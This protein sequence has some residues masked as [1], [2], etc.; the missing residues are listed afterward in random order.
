MPDVAQRP[1]QLDLDPFA[2]AFLADPFTGHKLLRD[3]GPVVRLERYGIWGMA[4]HA[5]VSAALQDWESFCSGRGA[6]LTDFAKEHAWRPPSIILEAD[7]PLHTRTRGV[8]AKVLSRPALLLLREKMERQAELLLDEVLAATRFD[9]VARIAQ[10]FP[11]RVFPDAVGLTPEG[12][13][14]LLPYGDMAFNAF[15]PRNA[16]FERAMARASEVSG[17]IMAQCHRSA[18]SDGGIGAQIYAEADAGV[19]SEDEAGL[20]V[21][22]LLTAGLDTTIQG[23]AHALHAFALFPAE[24][25]ILRQDPT[26]IRNAFE[27][28]IRY[29]SPVQTFFR[30]TT[31]E[32]EVSG[33]TLPEG[34]KVLLFLAAANRDPRRWS[35]PDSF[36]VRRTAAGHVG[37]G[38][39]IHQCVGQMV[40]R[41]ETEVLLSA[42]IK[43]VKTFELDGSP[44]L[45]LNN[46]LRTLE[47]LPLRVTLARHVVGRTASASLQLRV[48]SRKQEALDI[49]SFDLVD[50]DAGLLPEF[51]AGAHIELNLPCGLRRQYS[52]C[53]DPFDRHRYRIAVLRETASRGGSR[54]MHE[55]L[56]A[57]HVL[58]ASLPRNH[59][60]LAPE[61]G[62]S[63]LLAGGIGITPLYSMAQSL[64][65][66][67][68]AF[69]LH[70]CAKSAEHAAFVHELESAPF[71]SRVR[72]HYSR[73]EGGRRL[74]LVSLLSAAPAETHLYVCGPRG[75]IEAAIE[76]ARARGW[77]TRRLHSELFGAEVAH[78][79]SD[80]AFEV[81][82]VRSGRVVA[83]PK[84]RTVI[85][86]LSANGIPVPVSCEQG[87]CGTCLTGVLQGI[88]D[89]RD[90]YLTDDERQRNDQF[91]PCCSRSKTRRLV[92]DL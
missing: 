46:T 75:F 45:R 19:I 13:E 79:D 6:G 22:S 90:S 51:A 61:A 83:I 76:A 12:R 66:Q 5:E 48:A 42:L 8:L 11:L 50:P 10:A 25:H 62:Y 71:A 59:F 68:A 38:Y 67:N 9:A 17:W 16:I 87:V 29:S 56:E 54:E 65:R 91:T 1:I 70:Y 23:L 49:C 64:W 47:Q 78:F 39:G 81:E 24:W 34:D 18:L 84:D 21:R 73:G 40:A 35:D 27:E 55:K 60:A 77:P 15:G 74:D 36:S 7:P 89:H 32:I 63:M 26:L 2:P 82:L 31:R 33:V 92:L 52:I 53:S 28:A 80:S 58:T 14:N 43:K 72:H 30:T 88:P 44:V 86:S 4:R 69:E 85:E 37:F 57:G 3:A 20:L 41:L